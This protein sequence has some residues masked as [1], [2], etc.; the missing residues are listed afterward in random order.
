[1]KQSKNLKAIPYYRV[2]IIKIK[3]FKSSEGDFSQIQLSVD[4]QKD[5]QLVQE[6]IKSE[7]SISLND[8]LSWYQLV[9]I[10]NDIVL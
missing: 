1:M 8:F 10:Y 3:N 5:F 4:T 7:K 2:R 9:E 6:I